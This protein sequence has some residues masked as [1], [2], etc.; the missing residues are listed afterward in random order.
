MS[1]SKGNSD[2]ANSMV[3]FMSTHPNQLTAR[4]LAISSYLPNGLGFA[5]KA[6]YG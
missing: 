1:A 3:G 6:D 2:I 5:G 4:F